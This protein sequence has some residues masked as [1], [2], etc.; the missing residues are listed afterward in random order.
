MYEFTGIR[1]QDA[2]DRT[3]KRYEVC[4]SN[5]IFKAGDLVWLYNLRRR[6]DLRVSPKLMYDVE[7]PCTIVKQINELLYRVRKSNRDKPQVLHGNR[8]WRLCV[9][10][11][12]RDEDLC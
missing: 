8:L 3:E 6:K 11:N 1:T 7:G 12:V 2:S 5:E 4:A 9:P 10:I